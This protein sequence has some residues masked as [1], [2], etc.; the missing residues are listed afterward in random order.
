MTGLLVEQSRRSYL[1]GLLIE[2]KTGLG[3]DEELSN[4]GT[5]IA[6]KLDHLAHALGLGVTDDGA[7]ASC[8]LLAKSSSNS[9]GWR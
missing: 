6:L 5:V 9:A 3:V 1:D 7:I 4:L 2:T 8:Q